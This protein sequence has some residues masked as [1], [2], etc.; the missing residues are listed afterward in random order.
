MAQ[1][2]EKDLVGYLLKNYDRRIRP[3][4][5]WNSSMT[6]TIQIH[7]YSLIDV[8]EVSEQLTLLLWIPQSWKDEYLVW[9]E[10]E[11][12]GISKINIPAEYIWI[13]DGTIFN[14]VDVKEIL[15]LSQTYARIT[16]HGQVEVDFNKLVS[17]RC[18]MDVRNF[19]FDLQFCKIQFGSWGFQLHQLTHNVKSAVIIPETSENSEWQIES[20]SSK[21]VQTAYESSQGDNI[22]EYEEIIYTI[23]LRR[24][25]LY[26][27]VVLLIPTYLI[28][29]ISIIGLFIPHSADGER[30]EKVSF[31]LTTLLTMTVVLGMVTGEMPKSSIGLPLLGQYVLI[32]TGVSIFAIILSAVILICNERALNHCKPPP[33]WI[34]GLFHANVKNRKDPLCQPLLTKEKDYQRSASD[35]LGL[36]FAIRTLIEY[37]DEQRERDFNKN[38]WHRLFAFVDL[39]S[40]LILLILNTFLTFYTFFPFIF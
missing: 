32:E 26:Y 8:D 10:D 19:P 20:F 16:S 25:P 33:V 15:S 6:I 36:T 31:G 37:Y 5:Y 22:N 39:I 1:K 28:V 2:T 21:K 27:I 12:E 23:V 24:K 30:E 40:M 14:I 13:P 18:P 35:Q 29:S 4:K 17:I 34:Q 9:N 7:L 38:L 11:W 3:T